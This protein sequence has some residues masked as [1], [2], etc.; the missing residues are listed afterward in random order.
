MVKSDLSTSVKDDVFDIDTD[1]TFEIARGFDRNIDYLPM[2][3]KLIESYN[4]II[5][6]IKVLEENDMTIVRRIIQLKKKMVYILVAMIQLRNGSRI[7]EACNAI[8]YFFIKDDYQ[9]K[10]IVKIAK[11][12]AIKYKDGKKIITKPRYRKM[13][14]P[15][16]WLV[17]FNPDF[18]KDAFCHIPF[19]RLKKRVLDY[20]LNYHK[21]N[22]H[23]LRYA[24]INYLIYDMKR[25]L[26][27]VAKFV[28]HVDLSMLTKYTQQKNCEKIFDLDM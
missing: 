3:N 26:N 8:K 11:S 4:N 28:G 16:D 12:E 13:I 17:R 24:C 18:V 5:E 2:K 1:N 21:C 19:N 7:S 14:F 25:P 10:L 20:L 6:K 22:T 23:S 15:N 9:N 27:D